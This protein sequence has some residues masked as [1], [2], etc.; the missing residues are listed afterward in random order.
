MY[1]YYDPY[2]DPY[3]YG[4]YGYYDSYLHTYEIGF[5]HDSVESVD[6]V[7]A[8]SKYEALGMFFEAYPTT[9]Y[10]EVMYVEKIHRYR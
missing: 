2:D 1:G 5:M 6:H 8:D 10:S 4:D 7:D 3:A 9:T